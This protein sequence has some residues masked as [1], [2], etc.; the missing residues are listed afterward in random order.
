MT[1]R[2]SVIIPT[3]NY[4]KFLTEALKSALN[5][6]VKPSEII[7]VDDGST[8]DTETI[9]RRFGKQVT[10]IKQKNSG[11]SVARNR[12]ATESKGNF[13]AFLDSDDILDPNLI[14]KQIQ[15][16]HEDPEIGLVH[17]GMRE[18]DSETGGTI[19][20]HLEGGEEGIADN[21]LLW[22]GP[23]YVH[24]IM[25]TRE[26]F[27]QVGG[28][29]EKFLYASSEDWDFCYRVARRF[30]VG[31]VA[32]PLYNYRI[33]SEGAHFDVEKLKYGMSIFYENAFDTDEVNILDLKNRAM[34]NFH[35]VLAG[36]Y[37][38]SR[39]YGKFASH[40]LR[41]ILYRPSNLGYFL[42]RLSARK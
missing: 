32:E 36:S 4:G 33:H 18:F 10:Y 26:A 3:Y 5:Q 29:D 31:F 37:F 13:L 24:G 23:V 8:D 34:G 21:L 2:V 7:V 16:F 38:A 14:A 15:R 6:T 39:R 19:R 9:V 41:S 11:V 1:K 27:D 22:E 17:C 20:L 30:R 12:G 25:V 35:R 28:F 40:A 42:R